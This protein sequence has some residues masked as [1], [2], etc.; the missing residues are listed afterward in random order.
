MDPVVIVKDS[1]LM[2]WMG[3][4]SFRTSHY[5]YSEEL[6]NLA[7]EMGFAVIDETPAVGIWDKEGPVFVEGRV[8]PALL[9]HHMQVLDELV[10]RDRN[11]PCVVMWSVANEPACWEEKARDYFARLIRHTRE[12][13]PTRPVT[14]V[15]VGRSDNSRIVDLVDVVCINRYY[16]WYSDPGRI[17]VVELQ[18]R[19]ELEAMHAKSGGRP[20][21]VTEYGADT[22]A[23]LHQDPPVMFSE[24][25]QVAMLEAFHRVMD[26]LPFVVGEH[27]WNFADFQTVQEARRVDGNKKGLFTRDRR[28]KAAAHMMRRRWLGA[29]PKWPA[30]K[31][32]R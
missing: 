4:N 22:I 3:A 20:V 5:P 17:E 23:G 30:E 19:R 27:V 6:M 31:G 25:Y 29:S 1:N 15:Q 26:S 12:L 14:V 11:H 24:E 8:G 2:R 9:E 21:M 7:D 18:L 28:P 16:S 13:D 10:A 32:S